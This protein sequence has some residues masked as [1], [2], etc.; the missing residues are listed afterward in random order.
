MGY[1][2]HWVFMIALWVLVIWALIT[3]V[4]RFGGGGSAGE[5]ESAQAILNRRFAQGELS[6]ADFEK[7][8]NILAKAGR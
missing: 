3:L 7:M 1:G 8:M 2:F 4:R 6:A 5:E